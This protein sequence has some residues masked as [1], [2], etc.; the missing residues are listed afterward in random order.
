MTEFGTTTKKFIK[1]HSFETIMEVNGSGVFVDYENGIVK[2]EW[3]GEV[4]LSTAS[5]LLEKGA[6]MIESGFCHRLLLNREGLKEFSTEARLWIKND[7]LKNQGSKLVRKVSKAATVRS[8]TVKGSIFADFIS[9]GIQ[10]VFP[11]LRLSSF[12]SEDE[13][14]DWLVEAPELAG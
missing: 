9:S 5:V 4:D 11:N 14:F 12:D 8:T 1:I 2:I 13:A 10:L 6:D 7:L 3:H